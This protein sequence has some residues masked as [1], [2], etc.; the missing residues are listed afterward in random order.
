LIEKNATWTTK[1]GGV[2]TSGEDSDEETKTR[3]GSESCYSVAKPAPKCGEIVSADEEEKSNK[4]YSDEEE[5]DEVIIDEEKKENAKE[6]LTDE[7]MVLEEETTKTTK[8]AISN[9]N[10]T[11]KYFCGFY[12]LTNLKII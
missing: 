4:Q 1:L 5:E 6:G 11:F 9:S 2:Y 3:S 10:C 7:M 8:T 12:L